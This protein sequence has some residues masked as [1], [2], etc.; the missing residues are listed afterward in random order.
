MSDCVKAIKTAVGDETISDAQATELLQ[1]MQNMA[2]ARRSE[3]GLRI[4]EALKE[5]AGEMRAGSDSMRLIDR[6]NRLLSLAAFKQKLSTISN[7]KNW[8]KGF[9]AQLEQTYA[10]GRALEKRF[11]A[12]FAAKVEELGLSAD[13]RAQ[14]YSKEFYLEA[15][16]VGRGGEAPVVEGEIGRKIHELMKFYIGARKERNALKNRNGAYYPEHDD[17]GFLQSYSAERVRN[18]GGVMDEGNKARAR[19]AFNGLIAALNVNAEKTFNGK[20]PAL[21]WKQVFDNLYAGTHEILP[22]KIDIDKF[23]GVHGS[24]ANKLSESRLIWFA[25]AE[26]QWAWNSA[27]G[28]GDYAEIMM[29]EMSGSARAVALMSEWGPNWKNTTDLVNTSLEAMGKERDDSVKQVDSLKAF[30]LDS[31]RKLVS[32]EADISTRPTLSRLTR[33]INSWIHTAKMGAA[34]ISSFPDVVMVNNQM[35]VNGIS[36]KDR[37]GAQLDFVKDKS[38]IRGLNVVSHSFIGSLLNRFGVDGFTGMAARASHKLNQLNFFNSWNDMNQEVVTSTLSW[39]LGENSGK[40]FGELHPGLQRELSRAGIKDAEWDAVRSTARNIADEAGELAPEAKQYVLLDG[41]AELPD[42]TLDRIIT[43]R[44]LTVSNANRQRVRDDLDM[45]LSTYFSQQSDAALNVPD[46]KTRYITT[47]GAAQEGSLPRAVGN[48][49]MMFKSFPISVALRFKGRVEEAGLL[50][51]PWG[52]GQWSFAFQQAKLI[53]FASIAGY[54]AM[55]TKDI[56]NGRTR[57]K[58]FG[59]DGLPNMSVIT[60][61]MARGGGLGIMGDFLFSEYDRQYKSALASLAGPSLGLIDPLGALYTGA[62]K[63]AS[64]EDTNE[65]PGSEL[66]QLASN[67]LPFGNLFYI[68]PIMNAFVWWNIREALSPGVLRRAERKARDI[69]YQDYFIEPSEI[70]DIPITEPGRK[71]E[72]LFGQ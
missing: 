46:L 50:D 43:S 69:N 49:L 4:D 38:V 16:N 61:S 59:E 18:L 52:K 40:V 8:G 11:M 5:I 17:Y 3:R 57:R 67:N 32:G 56:L 34:T 7:S 39:W 28:A 19:T 41:I 27:I 44:G 60:A 66:F 15:W 45:K 36:S 51:G 48:L 9:K 30:K 65:R 47:L 14:K 13:F 12:P 71:M 53:A 25:D 26:S 10:K 21:F 62:R 29:R 24:L 37:F 63:I 33:N 31:Y 64:G 54:A 22:D 58:L 72:A 2:E 1:R 42:A 55:T 35:A 68:R 70:A 23:S 20:D 6:R